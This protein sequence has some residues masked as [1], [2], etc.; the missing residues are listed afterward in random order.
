VADRLLL[1][2]AA[3]VSREHQAS[4]L[5]ETVQQQFSLTQEGLSRVI[6]GGEGPGDGINL[7]RRENFMTKD[8]SRSR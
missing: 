6:P 3:A 1:C 8:P 7:W 5:S 4:L 2:S